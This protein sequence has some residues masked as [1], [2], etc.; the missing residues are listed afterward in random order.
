MRATPV[1]PEEHVH[2]STVFDDFLSYLM[3]AR[4]KGWTVEEALAFASRKMN[5]GTTYMDKFVK[6]VAEM[7]YHGEGAQVHAST[8]V[9][10]GRDRLAP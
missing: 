2:Y 10:M 3:Q 4:P 7:G 8:W 5:D 1:R 9:E 6:A